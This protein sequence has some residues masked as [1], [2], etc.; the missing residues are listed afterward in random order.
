MHFAYLLRLKLRLLWRS[1]IRRGGVLPV[2][3]VAFLA[4]VFSPLWMGLA[5][6]AYFLVSRHGAAGLAS[7]VGTVHLGWLT[8]AFL[9]AAFAEGFDW[10]L[11][12]RY[13]IP[14]RAIFWI[15]VLLGPFDVVALFLLPPLL[16][17]VVAVA[18]RAGGAAAVATLVII[19][20]LLLIT[21]ATLQIMLALIG[22]L[23]KREWA[24][25][26]VG[27][28][29]GLACA[30]PALMF[31]RHVA[32]DRK[33]PGVLDGLVAAG[34]GPSDA[35]ASWCPTTAPLVIALRGALS[36][37]WLR[38]SVGFVF[39]IGLLVVLVR[40]GTHLAVVAALRGDAAGA[41]ASRP[42]P[43]DHRPGR[44]GL[45]AAILPEDLALLL[46]RE[47]RYWQRTPQV[48]IGLLLTPMM[49][50]FF[51]W[52]RPAFGRLSLFFVPFFC[53]ASVL[54][55]SANQFGLDREG[56]RLLFLL[57]LSP[58]RLLV[59]KNL[60]SILVVAMQTVAAL[61]ILALLGGST[62]ANSS[63]VELALAGLSTAAALPAVLIVGNYLSA[64]HPW[65]MTFRVGGTPPGAMA[66]AF[67]QMLVLGGMAVL[68][69]APFIA[70]W[71]I[72]GP[73]FR[74]G[75]PLVGIG[76]IAIVMWSI[77]VLLLGPTAD[78]LDRHREHLIATLAHPHETG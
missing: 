9:F 61:V 23:L 47:L 6:G 46:G 11:L 52:Q 37:H 42:A 22:G 56:T 16:A 10:R 27:L 55:L 70:A 63:V 25:A 39:A 3:G 30:A 67:A 13:P 15:N 48:I 12:L 38:F 51:V 4:A 71:I 28:T 45:L 2:V 54:S 62:D 76:V 69:A 58:R 5:G 65:R 75:G 14:P 60:A 31:N 29:F 40:I 1:F 59:A 43:R 18:G 20:L 72:E 35:F 26:A 41:G 66:S 33:G 32:A 50:T 53:L 7:L 34:L 36:G 44:R 8:S 49:V 64:A 21:G 24:R 57:P 68:L 73:D 17:A 77:W 19:V 78:F 74:Y